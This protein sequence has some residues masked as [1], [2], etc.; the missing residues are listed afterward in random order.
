MAELVVVLGAGES[1]MGAAYLA[2]KKGYD[3]FLSD[4][5]TITPEHKKELVAGG[6]S[7]S[8]KPWNPRQCPRG[9][10]LETDRVQDNLRD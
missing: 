2:Q 10:K 4:S 3:V 6:E 8:K 9:C 1:G 5:G 7:G